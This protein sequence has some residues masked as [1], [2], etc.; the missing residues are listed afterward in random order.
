MGKKEYVVIRGN[1]DEETFHR[2]RDQSVKCCLVENYFDAVATPKCH[3]RQVITEVMAQKGSQIELI[4]LESCSSLSQFKIQSE[5]QG[6]EEPN[7]LR[8]GCA[9]A[10]GPHCLNPVSQC[11]SVR[12]LW[13]TN[14]PSWPWGC[15]NQSWGRFRGLSR[16]KMLGA[17]AEFL[18]GRDAKTGVA[19]TAATSWLTWRAL[20]H[21]FYV[22]FLDRRYMRPKWGHNGCHQCV[23]NF[24]ENTAIAEVTWLVPINT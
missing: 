8:A 20:V 9:R 18:F 17:G 19:N 11:S 14:L 2:K 5:K 16:W 24:T 1:R 7:T 12:T 15:E 4:M 10:E 22:H 6:A 13:H 3:T 21:L 23:D